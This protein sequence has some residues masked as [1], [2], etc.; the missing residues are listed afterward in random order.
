MIGSKISRHFFSQSERNQTQSQFPLVRFSRAW[1]LLPAGWFIELLPVLW[2]VCV[3]RKLHQRWRWWQRERASTTLHVQHTFF[4]H[5][6]GRNC[7]TID[8]LVSRFMEGAKSRKRLSFSFLNSNAV[9][10]NS[11]P[12]KFFIIRHIELDGIRAILIFK[13]REFIL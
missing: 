5:F 1:H 2:L 4:G 7:T 8:V 9:L 10:L 13:Q 6:F 3:S 11:S 12:E